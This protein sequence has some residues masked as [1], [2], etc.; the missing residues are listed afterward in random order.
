MT[1]NKGTPEEKTAV[2][3]LLPKT[4]AVIGSGIAGA[5]VAAALCQRGVNVT[6]YE[7]HADSAAEASG[8]PA[9]IVML[10]L[11]RGDHA[12]A[13]FQKQAFL[14][15]VDFY[16]RLG[17]HGFIARGVCDRL[18]DAEKRTK[19]L[20][21]QLFPATDLYAKD[22][23]L[24][25]RLAGAIDPRATIRH[26]LDGCAVVPNKNVSQLQDISSDVIVI[27]AGRGLAALTGLSVKYH[28]GQVNWQP[29]DK[30]VTPIMGKGYVVGHGGTLTFG[31]TFDRWSEPSLLPHVT[32]VA[33]VEN[34][35]RAQALLPDVTFGASAA[36]AALRVS[37]H[38]RLPIAGH[39]RDNIYALG[40]LGA[41]GLT[42]APLL[43]ETLATDILGQPSIITD[44]IRRLIQPQRLLT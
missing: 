36:R 32:A 4:A 24:Y 13:R 1:F 5:C 25:H 2:P 38:D 28:A 19:L 16:E 20:E 35:A 23:A 26:L 15:A 12:I 27:A 6:V 14:Y 40:A 11:D 9:G 17:D 42:L 22:D 30:P 41:R 7:Q 37:S 44:D 43:A 33:T 21:A 29:H 8:N 18:F 39:L 3:L 34:T 31:A 10:R